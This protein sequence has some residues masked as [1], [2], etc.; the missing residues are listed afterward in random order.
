MKEK[1][2]RTIF[3]FIIISFALFML[4]AYLPNTS[5]LAGINSAEP[6]THPSNNLLKLTD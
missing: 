6:E 3:L 1:I 2:I 5:K 4:Y